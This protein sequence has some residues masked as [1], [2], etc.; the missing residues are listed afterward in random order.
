MKKVFRLI[1]ILFFAA[2]FAQSTPYKTLT[3]IPYY[4]N[5]VDGTY[6]EERCKLDLYYPVDNQNFPT[7]V[8]FHG[9][10]LKSGSKAIPEQLK[11]KDLAVVAVNYRLHPKVNA[12]K[13]IEDAAAA[14]A[15]VFKNIDRYGGDN[16]QIYVCGFSSGGY[17]SLMVSLDQKW[18]KKYK[19]E[20]NQIKGVITL[21]ATTF[22]NHTIRKEYGMEITQALIDHYA[23]VYSARGDA[24]RITLITGD[25]E[26]EFFGMYEENAYLRRMLK[27]NGHEKNE[28]IEIGGYGHEITEAGLP[29]LLKRIEFLK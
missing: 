21:S 6:Q 2:S 16:K 23:P 29:L 9:G 27:I 25:R 10:G 26:K 1:F 22:T 13:Y 19:L 11:G 15:W 28:L 7:V 18:L 8:W 12:P 24:P 5:P 3:D 20:A 14:V 4:E 17:L